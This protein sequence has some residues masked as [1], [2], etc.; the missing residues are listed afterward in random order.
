M[1]DVHTFVFWLAFVPGSTPKLTKNEPYT[2]ASS[3]AMQMKIIL[4]TSLFKTP[5]LTAT[6]NVSEEQAETF[7]IDATAVAEALQSAIGAEVSVIV[8]MPDE[9]TK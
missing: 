4:P 6:V 8:N 2:G 5:S 9:A 3:R 1:T 7:A